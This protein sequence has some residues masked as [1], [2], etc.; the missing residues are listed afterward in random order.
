M[1][2]EICLM[3]PQQEEGIMVEQGFEVTEETVVG[4][5]ST[6]SDDQSMPKAQGVKVRIE[7]PAVRRTLQDNKTPE[8]GVNNPCIAKEI[9]CQLRIL[10][11]GIDGT[12]AYANKVLFPNPRWYIWA[13]VTHEFYNKRTTMT[14]EKR[15][16]LNP[17]KS[18][19]LA[20]GYDI[21]GEV[22]VNDEFLAA[23]EGQ[24]LTIDISRESERLYQNGE[25]V[26]TGGYLNRVRKIRAAG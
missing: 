26:E 17:F 14:S 7:K 12:G 13:E 11:E 24:E 2:V 16:Y 23:I 3:L 4:D 10:P 18:L 19:L 1:G 6:V 15:P 5:L 21:K 9:N 20:L 8:D 25:W 22:K